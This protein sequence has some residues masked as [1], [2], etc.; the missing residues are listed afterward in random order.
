[1]R[2][3]HI[4]ETLGNAMNLLTVFDRQDAARQFAADKI[5][6]SASARISCRQRTVLGNPV[7]DITTTCERWW[8]AD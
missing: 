5:K 8:P 7:A 3:H 6:P 1:L 2:H 4:V